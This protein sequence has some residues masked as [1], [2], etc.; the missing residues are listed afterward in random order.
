VP[1]S[2]S[3]TPLP[4]AARRDGGVLIVLSPRGQVRRVLE[5]TGIPRGVVMLDREDLPE[6]D[7]GAVA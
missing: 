3:S 2:R 1:R 4:I 6:I 5:I 7:L